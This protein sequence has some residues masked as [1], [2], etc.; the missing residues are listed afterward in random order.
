[1]S[2]APLSGWTVGLGLPEDAIDAPIRR[3]LAQLTAA[4]LLVLGATTSLALALGG[5]MFRSL[6]HATKAAQA[7]AEGTPALARPS[8][9]L[10]L[11]QL[12]RGISSAAEVLSTTLEKERAARAEAEAANRSKDEFVAIVSHEL[13]TPLGA[14]SG[15]VDLLRS[16]SLDKA[17]RARA[18][19][20]I[21]R[22]TRIQAQLLNDLLDVSRMATGTMRVEPRP[23]ELSK[24]VV[25]AVDVV[26]PDA[27]QKQIGV[28]VAIDPME[29]PVAG[30]PDR[31]QQ[32]VWNLLSNAIKFTPS[33]GRIDVAL[34]SDGDELMLSIRDDGNGIAP[35]LLPHV[36]ERFRQGVSS[37]SR[38]GGLGIRPRSGPV[39]RGAARRPGACRERGR[40]SGVVL[41]G[42][43]SQGRAIDGAGDR[44]RRRGRGAG[45]R[46]CRPSRA[47]RR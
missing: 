10:E 34:T 31:L 43:S 36:F 14:I 21:E 37:A 42:T 40:G 27:E 22:N 18:L 1:L 8:R 39:P 32:I 44:A 28:F 35:D 19:E 13:R 4:G 17:Q 26:R 3:S 47:G 6:A 45:T 5:L 24:A 11:D 23:V 20:V 30:D 46:T 33:G 38:R 15:W 7:L 25:A 41:H 29:G 2:R 12:A 9:V 16:D